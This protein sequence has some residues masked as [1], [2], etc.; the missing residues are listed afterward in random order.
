MT[1]RRYLIL[2]GMVVFGAV[3]DVCLSRG[4]KGIGAISLSGGISF[5]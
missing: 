4:M 3:G 2:G 5:E 1:L